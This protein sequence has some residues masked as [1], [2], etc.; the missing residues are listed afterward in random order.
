MADRCCT[1]PCKSAER[2]AT[3]Q[4]RSTMFCQSLLG[5]AAV[6]PAA[7][8]ERERESRL[9]EFPKIVVVD[10]EMIAFVVRVAIA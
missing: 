6:V 8:R 3:Q 4:A 2:V 1:S 7:E 9:V 5:K 10:S